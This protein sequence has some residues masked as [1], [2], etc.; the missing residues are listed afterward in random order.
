MKNDKKAIYKKIVKLAMSC[1]MTK[2]EARSWMWMKNE[3]LQDRTPAD[4]IST[5][6]SQFLIKTMKVWEKKYGNI[7][8]TYQ[9]TSDSGGR[10][11]T[12][13]K[14]NKGSK[15]VT[16][17]GISSKSDR[18]TPP[19]PKKRGHKPRRVSSDGS[20]EI[21]LVPKRAKSIEH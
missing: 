21:G 7:Q 18:T 14:P 4:F 6:E 12:T 2:L 20:G 17:T 10:D 8:Q 15:A 9:E 19:K 3:I 11:Q 16:G 5:G 1:G 13:R